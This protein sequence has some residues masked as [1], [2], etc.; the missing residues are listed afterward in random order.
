[1]SSYMERFVE[2][3]ND[4]EEDLKRE[5]EEQ[6]RR[7]QYRI[8]V[9]LYQSICFPIYGIVRVPRRQYVTIDRHRLAYLNGI[10][11]RTAHSAATP[12]S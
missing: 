12:T 5:V 10:E 11:R 8:W 6:Q 2:R 1:M 7:W 4:A 9:T 3:L